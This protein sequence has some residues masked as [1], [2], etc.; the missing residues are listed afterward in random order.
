MATAELQGLNK[1]SAA[2]R[3]LIITVQEATHLPELA[4]V[5]LVL[6]RA[7]IDLGTKTIGL[8]LS[9]TLLMIASPLKALVRGKLAADAAALENLCLEQGVGALVLG[10]AQH[11]R[12]RGATP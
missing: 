1:R 10:L 2:V 8:A 6:A 5:P 3:H 11:G 4:R 12:E 7:Q 9:D